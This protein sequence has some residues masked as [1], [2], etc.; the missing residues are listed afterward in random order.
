MPLLDHT[1]KACSQFLEDLVEE[2]LIKNYETS[3]F[4]SEHFVTNTK[5]FQIL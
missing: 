4:F 2:L 3:W 1:K 5:A